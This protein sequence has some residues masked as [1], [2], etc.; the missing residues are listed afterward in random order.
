MKELNYYSVN[1]VGNDC[2]YSRNIKIAAE[3]IQDAVGKANLY[4][5]EKILYGYYVEGIKLEDKI[6]I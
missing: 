5:D 6:L 4:I 3:S 1:I 2:R